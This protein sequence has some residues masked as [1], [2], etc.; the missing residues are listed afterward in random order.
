VYEIK[1]QYQNHLTWFRY[2][3]FDS[4][5]IRNKYYLPNKNK[6]NSKMR[7]VRNEPKAK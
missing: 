7:K 1:K 6:I 3:L 2:T 4:N 5:L